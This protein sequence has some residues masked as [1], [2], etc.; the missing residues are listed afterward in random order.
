MSHIVSDW[1]IYYDPDPKSTIIKDDEQ[2]IEMYNVICEL[3]GEP[4]AKVSP[5]MLRF[6][7]DDD[8]LKAIFDDHFEFKRDVVD[9]INNTYNGDDKSVEIVSSPDTFATQVIR[10]RPLETSMNDD[11][12]AN[13]VELMRQMADSILN[14]LTLRGFQNITKVSYTSNAPVDSVCTH[15]SA[16]TGALVTTKE[17]WI[18]ETDGCDL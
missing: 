10:M 1:G 9:K 17:N 6:K 3:D 5:W 15:Y 14:G 11:D 2:V 8:P 4:A 12:E 13:I 7:I 18:I 16:E